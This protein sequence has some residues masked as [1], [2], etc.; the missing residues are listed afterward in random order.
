MHKHNT[1]SFAALRHDFK[2]LKTDWEMQERFHFLRGDTLPL[3]GLQDWSMDRW[4][5]EINQSSKEERQILN[6]F[7]GESNNN[8]KALDIANAVK[9]KTAM[10]LRREEWE[11]LVK[12]QNTRLGFGRTHK[13]SRHAYLD[14]SLCATSIFRRE[15]PLGVHPSI[16]EDERRSGN[17]QCITRDSRKRI[18]RT[19]SRLR[20]FCT[21]QWSVSSPWVSCSCFTTWSERPNSRSRGRNDSGLFGS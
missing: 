12:Y 15:F 1:A 19:M 4:V 18:T 6:K 14:D 2:S 16:F 20:V 17:S 5:K 13:S 10:A 8:T 3:H 21:V 11:T 9:R 7:L